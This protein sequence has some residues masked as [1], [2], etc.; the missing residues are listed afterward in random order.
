PDRFSKVT[1]SRPN[2]SDLA[3]RFSLTLPPRTPTPVP[4]TTLFRSGSITFSQSGGSGTVTGLPDT[5]TVVSGQATS[6]SITG[7]L[8][9]G[10][11][12]KAA[13][14]GLTY[15]SR[16]GQVL[17]GPATTVEYVSPNTSDL[18][19]A[20]SRTFT[21]RIPA[22]AGNTVTGYSGSVTFSQSGGSGTVTGLP[23][24]ETVVSGQATSAS[25]TGVLVGGVTVKAASSGLTY[26]TTSFQV[27]PGPATK[28]EYVSPNTSD[29]ASGSSRTFTARIRDAAGNTVTGYSG[30]ITFSQSGGSGTVTG[31]PD[32]ET[33]VS[34]QATS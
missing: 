19:S 14:S 5:E 23:D 33:V 16:G 22:A 31:L 34:G 8:V 6:A 7:V 3:S 26:D 21:A 25:I 1:S 13:S 18:A 2:S 9:G 4:Y 15:D 30:S 28:V 17:P 12:V 29:L 20:S 27:V 24:T 11:T 10:V 32:T